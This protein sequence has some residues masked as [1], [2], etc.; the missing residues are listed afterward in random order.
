MFSSSRPFSD[1]EAHQADE[2]LIVDRVRDMSYEELQEEAREVGSDSGLNVEMLNTT[3]MLLDKLKDHHE[4]AALGGLRTAPLSLEVADEIAKFYNIEIDKGLV[5]VT[6]LLH[7]IGNLA[8]PKSLLEKSSQGIAWTPE[9]MRQKM[10]HAPTGGEITAA[11]GFPIAVTRA[12]QEHHGKQLGSPCYGADPHLD[13]DARIY[14]DCTADA[15]YKEADLNRTNSRNRHLSRSE[16]EIEAAANSY[17]LFDDYSE[18]ERLVDNITRR[19]LGAQ[20]VQ[21]QF[22][23]AA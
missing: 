19:T 21:S 9:D 10:V 20:A 7:D 8:L 2:L 22:A 11:Y 13:F 4:D 5:L 3:F 1:F 12:I 17:N 14:R 16:R 23:V 6:A 18:S 15:D